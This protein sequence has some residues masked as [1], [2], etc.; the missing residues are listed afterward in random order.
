M[1]LLRPI[2]KRFLPDTVTIFNQSRLTPEMYLV[3][4][5][6]HVNFADSNGYSFKQTG[7]HTADSFRVVVDMANSEAVRPWLEHARW[8]AAEYDDAYTLHAGMWLFDGEHADYPDGALIPAREVNPE[9]FKAKG[10]R[11]LQTASC[12]NDGLD[13]PFQTVLAG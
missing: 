9:A 12:D 5:I 3:T 6:R 4:V 1:P 2:Q 13:A 11:L 10:L 7:S 8:L